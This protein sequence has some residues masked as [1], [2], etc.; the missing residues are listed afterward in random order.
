MELMRRPAEE[1]RSEAVRRLDAELATTGALKLS[2]LVLTAALGG[3]AEAYSAAEQA[4]FEHLFRPGA[5]PPSRDIS[6]HVLFSRQAADLRADPRF[7][8][9]CVRLGLAAHWLFTDR[10]PD[11]REEVA[12]LYDLKAE[13][14]RVVDQPGA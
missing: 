8:Q 12:G 9:L 4:S 11:F 5:H 7:V 14:A 13:C 10:W 1:A 2:T 3:V 6:V